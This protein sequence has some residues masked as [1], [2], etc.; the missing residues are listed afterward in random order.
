MTVLDYVNALRR[1][2]ISRVLRRHGD[3][4]RGKDLL[5]IGSGTGAQLQLLAEVCRSAVGIE[6]A[7]SQYSP[8]SL[9]E[10]QQ[11]DGGHIPFADASFDIVFSS[12]VI[13][14][15][16]DEETIH[17]EMRRVL[18]PGGIAVHIVP[19]HHWRLWTSIIHYPNL[20]KKLAS[21]LHPGNNPGSTETI[22]ALSANSLSRR[23]SNI[24]VSEHH[25]EFGNRFTEYH[26][27]RPDAWQRRFE[28]HGWSVE[29]VEPLGLAYTGNCLLAERVSLD[30]R[31][32]CARLLGSAT[33]L[34]IMRP[35]G[36]T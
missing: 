16:R 9:V 12:N 26:H 18:R 32:S 10:I 13:E 33:V 28:K 1:E 15:I 31:D 17:R 35:H 2:E 22:S 7:G 3:L 24:F 20:I 6:V 34:L 25:G 27:F 4:F 29:T 36:R 21:R 14:H 30:T 5:E 19:T 8:H 11:Y 23:L